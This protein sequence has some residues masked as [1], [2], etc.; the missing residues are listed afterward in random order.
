MSSVR[1]Q[2]VANLDATLRQMTQGAGYHFDWRSVLRWRIVLSGVETPVV[3]ILDLEETID[4]L[5]SNVLD[6]TL[7]VTLSAIH[8]VADWS[9]P[10]EAEDGYGP[11]AIGSH[12]IEDME[13][14][15]MS[16]RRRGGL[17]VDTSMRATRKYIE[18]VGPLAVVAE[19]DIEIRYRTRDNDPAT[20]I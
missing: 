8:Q 13:R 7:A 20:A 11:D 17:A 4:D 15:V 9:Q 1:D 14:A 16:D 6:R 19:V 5:A 12:L 3:M 2:L 10:D 18:Q